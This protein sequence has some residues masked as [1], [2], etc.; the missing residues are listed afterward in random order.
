MND[1]RTFLVAYRHN[2]AEWS[3]ELPASNFE[4]AKARL[5]QLSFA[6]ID[7]EVVAKLPSGFGLLARSA[8]AIRNALALLRIKP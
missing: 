3:L 5:S 2:G 1:T 7:G 6:R 4:D 8:T